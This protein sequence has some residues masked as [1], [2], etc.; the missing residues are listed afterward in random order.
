M[1]AMSAD[2]LMNTYAR[3]PVAFVRGEGAWLFDNEEHKY[4]DA[5]SGIGVCNLGH[6]D[7]VIADAIAD[8]ARTLIHTANLGHIELQEQLA[9]RICASAD[10]DKAFI[11]NTGAEAIECAIKI[12]RH[13]GHARGIQQPKILTVDGAFHGR[14][15]AAISASAPGK[16]QQ[17]FTPLLPGFAR[18]PFN[19]ADAV[20]HALAQD[21]DIVAVL[22]EPIQGEGGVCVPAPGYLQALRKICDQH[23]TL[24]IFDEIQCGLNRTGKTWAHQHEAASQPDLLTTAKALGNGLP[25]AACMGA[26]AAAETLVPGS[27]GSTFGGSPMACRAALTV[28]ERM[29]QLN[30]RLQAEQT[31][32][33]MLAAFRTKLENHPRVADIRGR[34]LMLGIELHDPAGYVRDFALEHH[35]VINVTHDT[36][37]RLLP[38]LIIDTDQA[39][40]IIETVIAGIDAGSSSF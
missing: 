29:E 7:P 38:P 22:L 18:V 10:M 28:L 6:A 11:T 23:G 19:N 16:L 12:A 25:V 21:A 36:V 40:Q 5:I 14:T 27:H 32:N 31:G 3:M 15:L 26:G 20:D 2:H 13:H 24:L 37:I 17:G 9:E 8:Q 34:G 4:L 1:G 35:V 30:V 33:A 39:D